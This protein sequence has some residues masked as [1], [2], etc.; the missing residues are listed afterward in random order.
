MVTVVVV[1]VVVAV[2]VE[3]LVVMEMAP[4]SLLTSAA[5]SRSYT[6]LSEDPAFNTHAIPFLMQ[7]HIFPRVKKRLPQNEFV[8]TAA[9]HACSDRLVDSRRR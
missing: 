7:K 5:A 3:V 4:V 6:L 8:F 2:A 1:V 9:A